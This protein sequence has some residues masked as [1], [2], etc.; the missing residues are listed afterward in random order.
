[1]VLKECERC[2]LYGPG[3]KILMK[4]RV[5]AAGESVM[6]YFEKNPE[7]AKGKLLVDF[8]DTQLG[9]LRTF[10]E[11]TFRKNPNYLQRKEA[12]EGRCKI[13]KVLETVQRQKDIRVKLK[14]EKLFSSAKQGD[15]YGVIEN[16]TAGGVYITTSKPMSKNELFSFY[17]NFVGKNWKLQ[18]VTLWA[19]RITDDYFG[20]GCRFADLPEGAEMD[21]RQFVYQ[22]Q[23]HT[24]ELDIR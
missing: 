1:M 22:R 16:I 6:L 13:L 3:G 14:L 21:I 12:W 19:K 18:A 20:Y 23:L 24:G 15:F 11:I 4:G 9:Y 17:H 5:E 2:I 7:F 8:F 10:C